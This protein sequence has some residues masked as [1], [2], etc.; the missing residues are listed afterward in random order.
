VKDIITA[1]LSHA[2][3]H[4]NSRYQDSINR[5]TR[6]IIFYYIFITT[7][8][9]YNHVT[10]SELFIGRHYAYY[11]FYFEIIENDIGYR[12]VLRLHLPHAGL[13]FFRLQ[14]HYG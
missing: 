10:P 6:Q 12:L 14:L 2:C 9:E 8:N 5:V 4:K 11:P 3:E 1:S 13:A 7:D